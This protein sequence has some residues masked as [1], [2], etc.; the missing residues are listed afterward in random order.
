[1]PE[2]IEATFLD[3]SSPLRKEEHAHLAHA[4]IFTIRGHD[5]EELLGVVCRYGQTLLM[6]ERSSMQPTSRQ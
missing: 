1:M 4:E 2:W 6:S 3:P 5:V